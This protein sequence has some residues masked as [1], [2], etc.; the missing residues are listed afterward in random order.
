M[1][2]IDY[3]KLQAKKLHKD[4]K[5]QD[6]YF[7]EE[8]GH[9][10]Y[11]YN[12]RFFDLDAIMLDFDLPE[13]NFSLMKAQ[14]IIAKL[15]GFNKW[16]DLIKGSDIELELAKLLFD[17]MHKISIEE[18]QDYIGDAELTNSTRFDAETKLDIFRQVFAN[19][20]GHTSFQN[21]YRITAGNP[22][23]IQNERPRP[24]RPAEAELIISLPL[25][26]ENRKVFIDVAKDLFESVFE[27]IEPEHPRETL[28]LWNPEDFIDNNLLKA[29]M[30]PISKD[31]AL[32]L[33]DA[34]LVPHVIELASQ[35][36]E[37]ASGKD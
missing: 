1:K 32:S 3:F 31:Y 19:F 18:W 28:E 35:A 26:E 25:N 12:S 8:L 21:D 34:L 9:H 29:D 15:A 6:T 24:S 4:Y 27:R 10:F 30:L 13:D 22:E 36:D 16:A 37:K 17:N 14:H 11:R 33:I 5:T 7:D 2:P 23:L 20:D